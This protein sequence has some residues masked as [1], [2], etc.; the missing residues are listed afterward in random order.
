MNA[1]ALRSTDGLDTACALGNGPLAPR[2]LS[3]DAHERFKSVVL[4]HLPDARTLARFLTRGSADAEDIV[5]DACIRAYR[6]IG[7]FADGNARAWVL[8]IV[9]HTAYNWLQKNRAT[10][11]VSADDFEE[12]ESQH[13]GERNLET[14]ETVLLTQDDS[15]R[16]QASIDA[17]PPIFRTTLLMCDVRGLKYRQ[18]AEAT[19]VSIGTVMSR[20]AR[21]RGRVM[22]DMRA[23]G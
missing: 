19:G 14:P 15:T 4:P 8:T 7:K 11:V 18:I 16:L 6:G 9:R 12:I 3:D 17:L 21:A 10:N 23:A 13:I 5:Q 22:A 2:N 20:L 1:L